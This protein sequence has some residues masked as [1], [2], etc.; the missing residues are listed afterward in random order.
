M[1][2]VIYNSI[3][4]EEVSSCVAYYSPLPL[5]GRISLSPFCLCNILENRKLN[6]MAYIY[7]TLLKIIKMAKWNWSILLAV[8]PTRTP[9]SFTVIYKTSA[10]VEHGTSHT[11]R[12]SWRTTQR[13]NQPTNQPTDQPTD[14]PTDWPGQNFSEGRAED[15]GLLTFSAQKFAMDNQLLLW[16][17]KKSCWLQFVAKALKK[18]RNKDLK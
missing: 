6:R 4:N 3:L 13:T 10:K 16:C 1:L 11:C 17:A 9:C 12:Q 7:I 15:I 18:K 14:R 8:K 2:K 5:L